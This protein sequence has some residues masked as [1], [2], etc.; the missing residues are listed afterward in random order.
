MEERTKQRT[1]K[2]QQKYRK[3]KIWIGQNV[4]EEKKQN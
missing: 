1:I 2:D 4:M 3:K